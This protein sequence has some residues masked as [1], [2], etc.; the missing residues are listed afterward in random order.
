MLTLIECEHLLGVWW[1][2][3]EFVKR[4]QDY[5]ISEEAYC[6]IILEGLMPTMSALQD[7]FDRHGIDEYSARDIV[8]DCRGYLANPRYL[9]DVSGAKKAYRE[10]DHVKG[11]KSVIPEEMRAR[12]TPAV[13]DA[14]V[15]S[16]IYAACALETQQITS[17]WSI[18]TAPLNSAAPSTDLRRLPRCES[19]PMEQGISSTLKFSV[20][21]HCW[22]NQTTSMP[23]TT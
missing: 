14:F 4:P 16:L 22:L 1:L 11:S 17:G 5:V 3:K 23:V 9:E 2:G 6:V 10:I 15:G 13:A 20:T 18:A 7:L 12:L 19:S 21:G 8:P